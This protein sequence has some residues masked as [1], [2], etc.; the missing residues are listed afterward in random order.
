MSKMALIWIAAASVNGVL[1]VAAGAASSHL[2]AQDPRG[3]ALMSAGAQYAIYHALALLALAALAGRR[4][5]IA[6]RLLASAGWLFVA[7]TILFSGSLYALAL[8]GLRFFVWVTP[9]GGIALMLGWALLGFYAWSA[10]RRA[11]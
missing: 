2:F 8:S 11:G 9:F 1:A 6:E 4:G 3:F 5:G 7:G 10:W